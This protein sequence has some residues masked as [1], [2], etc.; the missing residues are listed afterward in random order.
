MP[1]PP[2]PQAAD[3]EQEPGHD[4]QAVA[5]QAQLTYLLLSE[6]AQEQ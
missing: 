6:V 5:P 1:D 4:A 2:P 3:D